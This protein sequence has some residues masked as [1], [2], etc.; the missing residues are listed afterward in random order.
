M[1]QEKVACLT[2]N[3]ARIALDPKDP[4][5]VQTK[6]HGHGDVH[7]LLHSTGLARKWADA[8]LEWV[9][10]FQVRG[11][12]RG[13]AGA[14]GPRS[15]RARASTQH[16]RS[17]RP[18]R[19]PPASRTRAA[20]QTLPH[21]PPLSPLPPLPPPPSPP[22]DTNALVFRAL[23][24]ALGVSAA[25]AYDMNS[26]AVPR[27]VGRVGGGGKGGTGGWEKSNRRPLLRRGGKGG[28]WLD[29]GLA[30]TA[31]GA[32]ASPGNPAPRAAP[33]TPTT[34]HPPEKTRPRRR[35]ARSPS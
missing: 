10:F 25:N 8:G 35:S 20:S 12:P 32:S 31:A 33:E 18:P 17:T 6:P 30:A 34:A 21:P 7:A 22:Q 2:D 5:A 26:L 16:V 1:K 29:G 19:P 28:F 23:L 4:Y 27:K 11:A 3:D 13:A 15:A 24:T 14:G 9:C